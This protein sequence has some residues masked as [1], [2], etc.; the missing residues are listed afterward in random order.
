MPETVSDYSGATP[1]PEMSTIGYLVAAGCALVLLPLLPVLA[2]AWLAS[3]LARQP[4]SEP[5]EASGD[6]GRYGGG[7]D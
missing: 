4:G 2:L 1:N 3:R 7:A 5:T 6:V